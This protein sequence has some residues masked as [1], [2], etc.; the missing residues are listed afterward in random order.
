MSF[1]R[2]VL[3]PLLNFLIFGALLFIPAGTLNWPRAWIFLGVILACTAPT[4]VGL[5][6][7][8]RGLL[9]ERYKPLFQKGQPLE[10]KLV[11]VPF[12]LSY[13]ACIIFIPLD[14]FHLHVF[15]LPP[16][17]AS[18]AGM[19]FVIAG[20]RIMY[21]AMRENAFAAPVVK[22]QRERGQVVVDTGVYR[23]V[24]HPMY[25]GGVL[26]F[27]GMPLWLQSVAATVATILPIL[28][29]MVRILFEERF[30]RGNLEAYEDYAGRVR[31][32]L[33]PFV[34]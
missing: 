3:G 2:L 6:R 34:W 7:D 31:W 30:L 15:S 13:F 32:R 25:L 4:M 10:D 14:V 26:F 16:S 5:Y 33:V 17:W 18:W 11:L 23:W 27:L 8:D 29:L 9:E 12:V 24:R 21:L 1:F 20:W 19:L 28:L 22:L